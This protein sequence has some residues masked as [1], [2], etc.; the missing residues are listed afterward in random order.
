[1]D[2]CEELLETRTGVFH[3]RHR[4]SHGWHLT[5]QQ[6]FEERVSSHEVK[7]IADWGWSG[8]HGGDY[9]FGN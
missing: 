3:D 9:F 6:A 8:T 5:G 7:L 2:R 1:M 4:P